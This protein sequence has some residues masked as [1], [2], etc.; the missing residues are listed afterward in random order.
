MS[1][2]LPSPSRRGSTIL[3]AMPVIVRPPPAELLRMA[4][5]IDQMIDQYLVALRSAEAGQWEA[6]REGYALGWLLIRNIQ[7]VTTL[8]RHDEIMATAAWS[9]AR[10]AFEHS[11]RIVW[12]LHP[13]DRYE[14]ECRWLAFLGEYETVERKI[15]REASVDDIDLHNQKAEAIRHFREGV[16]SALPSGYQPARMPNL[17]AMLVALDT[18]HMYRLYQEGSQYVHGSMYAG[19]RYSKNLGTERIFGDF[20]SIVDWILPMRLSWLSLR[21]AAR[22]ILDRLDVPGRVK[23][24]W[25]ALN[26]NVDAAFQALM[27]SAERSYGHGAER[28]AESVEIREQ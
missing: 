4:D 5:A 24:N 20:T 9:N 19:A 3:L 13:A 8:A 6:P 18:P 15:V 22:L 23:P 7:A 26:K 17:R 21:E 1:D 11:V 16:I 2:K 27:S 14:A 25:S 12:M 28:G 10:V